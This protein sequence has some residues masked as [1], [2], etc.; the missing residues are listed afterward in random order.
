[1]WT[2]PRH[3]MPGDREWVLGAW[4]APHTDIG[5]RIIIVR[6][7]EGRGWFDRDGRGHEA[8]SIWTHLG[9]IR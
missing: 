3:T 4:P 9:K 7:I 5:Q 1:M 6:W 2:T 8:P